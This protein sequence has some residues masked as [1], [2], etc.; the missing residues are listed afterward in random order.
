MQEGRKK[1]II[2]KV[3]KLTENAL[4]PYARGR[5]RSRTISSSDYDVSYSFTDEY[6]DFLD[7]LIKDL[8]IKDK[9]DKKFSE[10]YMRSK[11]EAI[12]SK[13]IRDGNSNEASEYVDQLAEDLEQ[14]CKMQIVYMPLFGVELFGAPIK[15][16]NITLRKMDNANTNQLIERIRYIIEKTQN[17]EASKQSFI[18][19]Q[20]EQ[21]EKQVRNKTCAI[22]EVGAEPGRALELAE[23]ETQR[24]IDLLRY[25]IPALYS[26]DKRVV[27]G[28]QGEHSRQLRYV[29]IISAIE[30]SFN[31]REQVVG[32][33]YPLELSPKNIDKMKRIGVFILGE[34]LEKENPTEFE[35]TILLAIEWFSRSQTQLELKNKLLNLITV[36]ETF[37]TQGGGYPIQT[38]IAEGAS[39]LLIKEDVI[40]RK[41]LVERIKEFY[42]LRNTLSHG[43]G[44]EILDIDVRELT[45]LASSLIN[46]LTK[47][48][49]QFES[50]DDLLRWIE[51]R[52]LGGLPENWKEYKDSLS[53]L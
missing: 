50:K 45:Y 39:I 27:I 29:P 53:K 16:G 4:D 8:L 3:I 14:Y 30:D 5:K 2:K 9:L 47:M 43:R 23:K 19:F 42:G 12:I 25:A 44:K 18:K 17:D 28:L 20:T 24:V 6:V 38:S 26:A 13:L 7:A 35:K 1:S 52:R 49:D 32:S 22:F 15:I 40:R 34:L 46:I 31:S 48:K 37:L 36:F 33:L 41:R 11:V 21:T 51:Y 10:E